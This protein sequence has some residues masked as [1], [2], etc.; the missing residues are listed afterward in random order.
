[1]TDKQLEAIQTAINQLFDI[2][3]QLIARIEKLE[4]AGV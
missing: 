1:M 3:Q 4:Q 2:A